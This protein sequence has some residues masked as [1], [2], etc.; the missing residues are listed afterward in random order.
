MNIWQIALTIWNSLISHFN[1]EIKL[2]EGRFSYE[3]FGNDKINF[4]EVE[5]E[6]KKK[7]EEARKKAEEEKEEKDWEEGKNPDNWEDDEW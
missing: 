2:I 3:I 1:F 6:V 7:A 4:K 5:E